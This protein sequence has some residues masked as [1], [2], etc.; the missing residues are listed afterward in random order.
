MRAEFAHIHWGRMLLASAVAAGLSV[1]L[2]H[3][4]VII[5]ATNLVFQLR[6]NRTRRR[7]RGSPQGQSLARACPGHA[8]GVWSS[9]LGYVES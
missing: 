6:A 1:G 8:A 5:Y 3:L 4:V 2:A 9:V 7:S